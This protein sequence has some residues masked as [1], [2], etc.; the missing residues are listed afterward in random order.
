MAGSPFL[1]QSPSNRGIGPPASDLAMWQGRREEAS[2]DRKRYEPTWALCQAFIANKQWVGWSKRDR[3]IVAEPNPQNRERH[4]VNVLT[5][6]LM[7][8]VGKFAGDDLRPQMFLRQED[9]QAKRYAKQANLGVEYAWDEELDAD[10]RLYDAFIR[11]CAFGIAGVQAMWNPAR[12]PMLQRN[13]PHVN[14]KPVLDPEEARRQVAENYGQGGGIEYRDVRGCL[15]WKVLSPTNI[16]PP[17]GVDNERDFPWLVI[18]QP[19]SLASVRRQYG[20]RA[21]ALTEQN[22][23]SVD[24]MGLRDTL[25]SEDGG[26]PQ[27]TSGRLKGH[28][29]LYKGYEWPTREHS[30][31]RVVVWAQDTML[32]TKESFPYTCAGEPHTGIRFFKYNTVPDRFW[33]IGLVEPGIGPQRQRNRSRSQYIEMKDRAGLGRVYTRPGALNSTHLQGGKI[34]EVIEVRPGVDMPT[35]TS[36]TGPGPWLAMD[37]QMHDADMDKV[38]GMGQVTLGN[39]PGGTSAY[40]AMALLAEQ[41]DKRVGPIIKQIRNNVAWL[42]KYTLKDMK[43]YWGQQKQIELAGDDDEIDAFIFDATKLP[44]DIPVKCGKGAPSPKNQAAEIQK[45]FDL[46][47]RSISCGQPLTPHWLYESLE[48]GKALPIPTTPAEAQKEKADIENMLIAKGGAVEVSQIDNHDIHIA[49]HNQAI[50]MH[51]LIPNAEEVVRALS[52]HVQEHEAAKAQ[53]ATPGTTAPGLQGGFGAA[54]GAS[55]PVPAQT[56]LAPPGAGGPANIPSPGSA[57]GPGMNP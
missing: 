45:I 15:D 14:G 43:D 8:N 47:D 25:S 42:V 33:P 52:E 17:P 23:A 39:A 31:G 3:R 24:M 40:S 13:V 49:E 37:V 6:Y 29:M 19:A 11:M 48:Q 44:T 22:M 51:L 46:F 34:M 5:S 20:D 1:A 50:E 12:G 18:E 53:Q 27:T 56:P 38:M 57:P 26:V 21:D 41:D 9:E 35:E 36:G 30:N 32:E 55:G 10:E 2:K 7:T 28:A 54:G 16:L 4:T